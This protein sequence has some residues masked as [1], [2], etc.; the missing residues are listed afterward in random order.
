V[1][2]EAADDEE[3]LSILVLS[4]Q[5]LSLLVRKQE[6]RIEKALYLPFRNE[7]SG[8]QKECLAREWK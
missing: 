2:I 1:G 5:T 3:K 8:L 4:N 7:L 6:G